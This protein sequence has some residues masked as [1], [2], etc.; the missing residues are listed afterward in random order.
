MPGT[1]R[2]ARSWPGV[3]IPSRSPSPTDLR[4]P[5]RWDAVK[6]SLWRKAAAL[7]GLVSPSPMDAPV[8][9]VEAGVRFAAAQHA[10]VSDIVTAPQEEHIAPIFRDGP[11]IDGQ[12][13]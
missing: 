5:T 4:V 10:Y 8:C 1:A 11:L 7:V 12:P 9:H 2:T 3:A 6:G 13:R